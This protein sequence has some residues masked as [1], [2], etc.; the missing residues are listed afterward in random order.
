MIIYY[1]RVYTYI[2]FFS[3]ESGRKG[4]KG[5]FLKPTNNHLYI[6]QRGENMSL[7]G[8]NE[9]MSKIRRE[10]EPFL[11]KIRMTPKTELV[12]FKESYLKFEDRYKNSW[13][14]VYYIGVGHLKQMQKGSTLIAQ[15]LFDTF[16]FLGFVESVC[17]TLVDF[18]VMVLVAN[19]RDFHIESFYSTP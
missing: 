12:T 14:K 13:E 18:L 19:G 10:I 3:G 9:L 16:S 8:N 5:Q 6:G 11:D 1:Y 17:N 4:G 7:S 2:R 15:Q